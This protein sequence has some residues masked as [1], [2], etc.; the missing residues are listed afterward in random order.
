MFPEHLV[1]LLSS[2]LPYFIAVISLM[3]VLLNGSLFHEGEDYNI[4]VQYCIK[5]L[6]PTALSRTK[7]FYKFR[8][9][10]PIYILVH[11]YPSV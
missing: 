10:V 1:F 8:L 4:V 9:N 5:Y 7:A 2:P 6:I 11:K 3:S